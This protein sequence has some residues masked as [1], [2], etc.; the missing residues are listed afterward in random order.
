LKLLSF[1][2][3][4]LVRAC[5]ASDAQY[6]TYEDLA[7]ALANAG[8]RDQAV[9]TVVAS[10]SARVSLLL[11]WTTKPPVGVDNYQLKIG[12]ADAFGQMRSKEAIPFLVKNISIDRMYA[13]NIWIK[14]P[15][16]V[17]QRLAAAAALIRIGPDAAEPV[18]HAWSG[19][20]D[21]RDRLAA[22]FVMSK[23]RGVP[24][25]RNFLLSV[26]GEANLQR[27][28]AEEGLARLD[29]GR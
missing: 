22:I 8:T 18:I 2:V 28:W 26:L 5:S 23:L 4:M 24:G 19:L 9:A 12:L 17:E 20:T 29:S 10:G 16:V 11:S 15:E 6:K 14:S 3:L 25:A 1:T 13:V 7:R 21:Y 27:N